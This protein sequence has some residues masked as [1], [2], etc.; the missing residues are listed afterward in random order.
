KIIDNCS[1]VSSQI[2]IFINASNDLLRD[3]LLSFIQ[4]DQPKLIQ[5]YFIKACFNLMGYN[6]ILVRIRIVIIPQLIIS[7][8]II[9]FM[10]VFADIDILVLVVTAV[11]F[12]ILFLRLLIN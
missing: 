10:D 2:P 3:F 6:T 8:I 4:V 9:A 5:Q 12:V 1:S 11:R 7:N